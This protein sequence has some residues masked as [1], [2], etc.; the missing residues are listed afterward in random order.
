MT[1]RLLL[2]LPIVLMQAAGDG[3][4]D[5][6]QFQGTWT[7]VSAEKAGKKLPEELLKQSKVVF[8]DDTMTILGGPKEEKAKFKLDASKTPRTIDVT[9]PD[10]DKPALGIYELTGDTLKMCWRKPG[11]ERPTEFKADEASDAV[12]FVLKRE[13]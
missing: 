12:M 13:K 10:R 9:P 7:M 3:D 4:K 6:K 11:G 8:K 1:A 2:L 5:A